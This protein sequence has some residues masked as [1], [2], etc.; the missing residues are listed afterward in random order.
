MTPTTTTTPQE[1]TTPRSNYAIVR[2]TKSNALY[3]AHG[4]NEYTNLQTGVRGKIPPA[5]ARNCFVIS[6]AATALFGEYPLVEEM[7]MRLKMVAEK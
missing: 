4:E 7:V 1:K 6:L 3:V 2:H 5:T